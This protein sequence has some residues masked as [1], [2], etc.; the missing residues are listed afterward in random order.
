MSGLRF[1]T[2][3]TI[4][5]LQSNQIFVYD[6]NPQGSH[7]RD[8]GYQ[9]RKFG[10]LYGIGRGLQGQSYGLI[11]KNLKA[12]YIEKSS[13]IKYLTEGAKSVSSKQIQHNIDELYECAQNTPDKYFI[14]GYKNELWPEGDSKKQSNGYTGEEMFSLFTNGKNV[15]NNVILHES[16]KTLY[17]NLLEQK[18]EIEN[19]QK[20]VVFAKSGSTFSLWHPAKIEYKDMTFSSAGQFLLYSKAKLFNDERTANKIM[21]MNKQD[22]MADFLSGSLTSENIMTNK[23]KA[24][25][26][27][28][29][30]QE[31]KELATGIVGYNEQIWKGKIMS[32]LGVAIRE[33]YNQNSHLKQH[34]LSSKNKKI[35]YATP[36]DKLLGAGLNKSE[37]L[38][39][40]SDNWP[41]E[42][43]L[44]NMLDEL[45]NSYKAK[46][47]H[48]NKPKI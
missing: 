21:N 22:I 43:L 23:L 13:G 8:M 19:S 42:N 17:K 14:V 6:S 25:I 34:L 3:D 31:I 9:A 40:T 11:T 30:Q 37:I 45:K 16:F 39:S 7:N 33:K 28:S 26:W 18:Q 10:A 32:I 5:E 36:T 46:K 2:G 1:W 44:G 35:I 27:E 29:N 4:K 15:P 20:Y 12:N 41:G 38:K 48:S 47:I 24:K